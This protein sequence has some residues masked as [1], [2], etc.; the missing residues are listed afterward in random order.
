[1]RARTQEAGC[2]RSSLSLPDRKTLAAAAIFSPSVVRDHQGPRDD[3]AAGI[4][5]RPGRHHNADPPAPARKAPIIVP[6]SLIV[7]KTE[8]VFN[9]W[10][11]LVSRAGGPVAHALAITFPTPTGSAA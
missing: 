3:A 11:M 6:S 1:M 5:V 2:G 8:P 4:V 7:P 9:H 10:Q